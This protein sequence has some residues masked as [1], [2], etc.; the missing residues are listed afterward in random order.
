MEGH[1]RYTRIEIGIYTL[2]LNRN[3]TH[4][5]LPH[6]FFY[7]TTREEEALW[8]LLGVARINGLTAATSIH[9]PL[10]LH[11]GIV[12]VDN[13]PDLQAG[14]L[15]IVNGLCIHDRI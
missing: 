13:I 1:Y 5:S 14:Q 4:L 9:E 2:P 3:A 10:P 11:T 6:L 12:E 8:K 15:K 7:Y